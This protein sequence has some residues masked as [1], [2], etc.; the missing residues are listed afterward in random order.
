MPY[1]GATR[2]TY[3]PLSHSSKELR[4]LVLLPSAN[5]SDQIEC[6]LHHSSLQDNPQYEALSYVWGETDSSEPILLD[7]Q[8]VIVRQNLLNALRHLRCDQER[9]LWVDAICIDQE[10]IFERNHQVGQM[11]DIYSFASRV[12]SWLG[13]DSRHSVSTIDFLRNLGLAAAERTSEETMLPKCTKDK[14][15]AIRQLL[16]REYWKRVW[17]VLEVV[18]ARDI[19][20]VCGSASINW[21]EYI[22]GMERSIGMNIAANLQAQRHRRGEGGQVR[23]YDILTMR[24][25]SLSTDPRDKIFAFLAIADDCQGGELEADYSKS[26]WEVYETVVWFLLRESPP[27]NSADIKFFVHSVLGAPMPPLRSLPR[28]GPFLQRL[29]EWPSSSSYGKYQG[30]IRRVGEKMLFRSIDDSSQIPSVSFELVLGNPK[31]HELDK[32]ETELEVTKANMFP[33]L[34]RLFLETVLFATRKT[35]KSD[36]TLFHGAKAN[37]QLH[38]LA[39]G[40]WPFFCHVGPIGFA[41]H[42]VHVGD[43]VYKYAS[44]DFY[45]IVRPIGEKSMLGTIISTARFLPGPLR[46][47][48]WSDFSE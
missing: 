26:T 30:V 2:F 9:T 20:V 48:G 46:K 13:L 16:K 34:H 1:S 25:D 28:L 37:R 18:L 27:A 31:M 29:D 38:D 47:C 5:F 15:K 11:G 23:L 44:S 17:I 6:R 39:D 22:L 24:E 21:A 36:I 43:L 7:G 12:I 8:E 41:S 40:F 14:R 32:K 4:L 35:R 42:P 45:F 33:V 3:R 10:N 19:L